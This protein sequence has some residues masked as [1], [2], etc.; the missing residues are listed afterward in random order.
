MTITYPTLQ[1]LLA[2]AVDSDEHEED[3]TDFL[4]DRR[5]P[6]ASHSR[7][8]LYSLAWRHGWRPQGDD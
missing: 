1:A 3:A 4:E 5:I 7:Q 8:F 2:D 6:Y